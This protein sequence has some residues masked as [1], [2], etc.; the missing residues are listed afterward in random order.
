VPRLRRTDVVILLRCSEELMR[1]V[2]AVFS[3]IVLVA[4]CGDGMESAASGGAAGTG[5]SAGEGGSAGSGASG[6]TGGTSSASA[7]DVPTEKDA[8]FAYLKARKYKDFAAESAAHASAGP[9]AGGVRVFVNAA[10]DDSL[11][12]KNPAHPKGAAAVKELNVIAGEP[13][14]WAVFVKTA[15]DSQGGDEIYWYEILNTSDG[16]N[17]PFDGKGIGLCKN[18]HSGGA[19]FYLSAY[20]LQ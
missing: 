10:L 20:P 1:H 12:A 6:G 15:D 13:G 4:G 5:G 3:I 17:P 7:E 16:S 14:G 19:D 18:C 11:K 8:I 2:F 9:H